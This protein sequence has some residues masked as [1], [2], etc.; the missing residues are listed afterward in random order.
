MKIIDYFVD[1][2]LT[3]C[4]HDGQNVAA[5][6]LEGSGNVRVKYCRRCGAV[7]VLNIRANGAGRAPSG[8]PRHDASPLTVK[9]WYFVRVAPKSISE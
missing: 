1:W 7:H 6:L 5:D 3:R 9:R 4:P 8:F 2:W